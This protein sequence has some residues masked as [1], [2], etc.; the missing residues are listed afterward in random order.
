MGKLVFTIV[1]LAAFG[2]LNAQDTTLNEY[3]GTY[4]FPEG[5]MV[6][7]VEIKIENGGLMAS[8]SAGS[9]ALE[10]ISRDTFNLVSYSGTVYFIRN[11]EQKIDSIRINTQDVI[12]EGKKQ[13][14]GSALRFSK[15]TASFMHQFGCLNENWRS[16]SAETSDCCPVAKFFS[17]YKPVFISSSPMITTKGMDFFSAYLNCLSNFAG[18]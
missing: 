11:S 10:K 13:S 7:S 1:A 6:T 8:S 18:S 15:L 3:V 12:L 5:S 14:G 2:L 4:T 9:S 16:C 17:L